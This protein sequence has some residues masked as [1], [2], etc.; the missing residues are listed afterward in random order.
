MRKI[1]LLI[2]CLA[3]FGCAGPSTAQADPVIRVAYYDASEQNFPV[4]AA[5]SD[6]NKN[7]VGIR[8]VHVPECKPGLSP[9]VSITQ[10]DVRWFN[11]AGGNYYMNTEA[12]FLN[13]EWVQYRHAFIDLNYWPQLTYNERR[14]MV[15]HELGHYLQVPHY[16]KD[17][18][19]PWLRPNR[20]TINPKPS[21]SSV[22]LDFVKFPFE[23]PGGSSV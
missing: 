19:R 15:C 1:I 7:P 21:P 22:S 11:Q 13:G 3:F 2:C 16:W 6:W 10:Y 18:M 12:Y 14:M 5:V 4:K 9:C 8:L 17:C 20:R 23:F